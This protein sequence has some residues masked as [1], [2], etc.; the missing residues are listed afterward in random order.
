MKTRGDGPS[1]RV[2]LGE[3]TW[4][5][6][7]VSGIAGCAATTVMQPMDVLRISMHVRPT[8]TLGMIVKSALD[9]GGVSRLWA[10]LSGGLLRQCTYTSARLGTYTILVDM[11]QQNQRQVGLGMSM[12]C[13]SIGGMVGSIV[14]NPAEVALVRLSA[15]AQMPVGER[16]HYAHALDALVRTAREEGIGTWWRGV[17]ATM[18]RAVVLNGVQLGVYTPTKQLLRE[19]FQ[20]SDGLPLYIGASLTSGV[21]AAFSSLPY[22]RVKNTLQMMKPNAQGVMPFRG[23][24]DCTR[25]LIRKNGIWSL[26][27][28]VGVYSLKLGPHTIIMFVVAEQLR[29]MLRRRDEMDKKKQE[30]KGKKGASNGSGV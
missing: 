10:G 25:Q 7:L 5:K 9:A 19:T 17:S 28:G 16:R 15:D 23:V 12:V 27:R 11:Y 29:T 30:G 22:D 8:A 18:G 21:I 6:Y 4:M 26:W 24:L 3:R 1:S 13:G 2:P 20:L 14:G